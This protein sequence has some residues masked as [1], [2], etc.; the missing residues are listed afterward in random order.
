MSWIHE[1]EMRS[2][3]SRATILE[4]ISEAACGS[5]ALPVL[6]SRLFLRKISESRSSDFGI[7]ISRP[8]AEYVDL[9]TSMLA[10]LCTCS[11]Q[12]ILL[13]H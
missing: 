4:L 12:G 11:L 3:R 9:S 1:V 10:T 13:V 2:G 5:R 7:Y 8:A 6:D